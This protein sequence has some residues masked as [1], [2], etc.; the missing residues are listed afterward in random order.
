[1]FTIG[2][3]LLSL[4][5]RWRKCSWYSCLPFVHKLVELFLLSWLPWG[6]TQGFRKYWLN[7]ANWLKE[8]VFSCSKRIAI[9]IVCPMD[10]REDRMAM[11]FLGGED[12][13]WLAWSRCPLFIPIFCEVGCPEWPDDVS[14]SDMLV[15]RCLQFPMVLGW[16]LVPWDKFTL[17]PSAKMKDDCTRPLPN[18]RLLSRT[19]HSNR[20]TVSTWNFRAK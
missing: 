3:S 11:W 15:D 17:I 14:L 18:T 20:F 9:S 1:M 4:E 2:A 6:L 8:Y 19:L 7:K 13:E 12:G 5:K 10:L 16:Y